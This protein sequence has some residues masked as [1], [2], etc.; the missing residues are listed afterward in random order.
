MPQDVRSTAGAENLRRRPN[1][2]REPLASPAPVPAS[3][4]AARAGTRYA[5][6]STGSNVAK[7][8]SL[9][10]VLLP[11]GACTLAVALAVAVAL[12]LPR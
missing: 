1:I 11:P 5:A 7:G 3:A 10:L 12:P 8:T 4:P 6:G 2:P 9:L